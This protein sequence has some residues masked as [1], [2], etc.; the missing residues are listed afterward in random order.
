MSLGETIERNKLGKAL[1]PLVTGLL[2]EG[3]TSTHYLFI[4][5]E[6]RLEKRI[7]QHAGNDDPEYGL[8]AKR[9]FMNNMQ[10]L[11]FRAIQSTHSHKEARLKLF[12]L[13]DQIILEN[14][15]SV[16]G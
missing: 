4:S 15:Y 9:F 2:E 5:V 6:K 14:T 8:R 7:A 10:E 1:K 12:T 3:S 16:K 11:V 13:I